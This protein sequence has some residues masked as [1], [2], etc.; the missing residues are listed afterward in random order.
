M[1]GTLLDHES[2][3][4]WLLKPSPK[5]EVDDD[6]P[7]L[8]IVDFGLS[9]DPIILGFS[10]HFGILQSFWDYPIILGG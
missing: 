3:D 6:Q 1:R 8:M 9:N 4:T 2:V 5:W 10:N 7:Y